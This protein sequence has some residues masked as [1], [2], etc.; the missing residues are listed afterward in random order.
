MRVRSKKLRS[1]CSEDTRSAAH[2][3]FS[4]CVPCARIGHTQDPVSPFPGSRF[5]STAPAGSTVPSARGRAFWLAVSRELTVAPT[6]R[7]PSL[8][9]TR[10]RTACKIVDCF[11]FFATNDWM[12]YRFLSRR[13]SGGRHARSLADQL[14]LV[15]NDYL[16]SYQSVAVDRIHFLG[17]S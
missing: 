13:T 10:L 14:C 11:L 15:G 17:K 9:A 12:T 4:R 8:M 5:F 3:T 1:C 7:M 2:A 6:M 16:P